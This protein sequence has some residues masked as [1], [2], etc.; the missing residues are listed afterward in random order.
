[1]Y[2]SSALKLDV[3][4]ALDVTVTDDALTVELSDGL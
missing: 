3:P 2:P 4:N 1:V